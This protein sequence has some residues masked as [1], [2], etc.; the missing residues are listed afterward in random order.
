MASMC[1]VIPWG[2]TAMLLSRNSRDRT[3]VPL[4]RPHR[5]EVEKLGFSSRF[6]DRARS[7]GPP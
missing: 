2:V 4:P 5:Q 6:P 7:R 3:L 1:V